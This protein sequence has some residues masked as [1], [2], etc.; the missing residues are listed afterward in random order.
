MILQI[1]SVIIFLFVSLSLFFRTACPLGVKVAGSLLVLIVSMKYAIYHFLG[2]A[3]FS[4]ELP[5]YFLL[6][7]EALYGSLI[8]LFFLLLLFDL[9]LAG[10]WILGHSGIPVPQRIPKGAIKCGLVGIA[11]CLGIWGTWESVRVPTPKTVELHVPNLPQGLEGTRI[12]Q[13]SD[14][15]IGPLLKKDWLAEVVQRTNA[16]KPDIIAMTGD[17]VDGH[18]NHIAGELSPLADLNARYGVYGVTGNHE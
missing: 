8:M 11:L 7:M 14:L 1:A 17:Y 18:V 5:R 10:N 2:G 6:V 16:L 12:V 4:P 15:H 9:Y 13:L 3:F